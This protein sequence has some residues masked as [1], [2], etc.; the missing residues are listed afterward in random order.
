M[1]GVLLVRELGSRPAMEIHDNLNVGIFGP[2]DQTVEILQAAPRVTTTRKVR[3]GLFEGQ[4]LALYVLLSVVHELLV[5]PEPDGD[6]DGVEPETL[7][8]GD[9]VLRGPRVPVGGERGIRGILPQRLH[10]LPLVV[11]TAAAHRG[12]RV[13]GHPR[14]N[15][16]LRSQVHA[17]DLVQAWVPAPAHCW[18][19][20]V[21]TCYRDVLAVS[22]VQLL[23]ISVGFSITSGINASCI[24]QGQQRG[25][26]CE[27]PEHFVMERLV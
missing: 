25:Q 16:E 27:V 21:N 1:S 22:D 14:L 12:P 15:N 19:G 17:A 2:P 13:S 5:D 3:D 6:A 23:L 26:D 4:V 7:D 18:R 10:A 8:L 9:V 24:G 11:E 20:R